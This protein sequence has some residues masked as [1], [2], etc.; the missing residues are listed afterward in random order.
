MNIESV[1][2]KFEAWHR[3]HFGT[4]VHRAA[5]HHGG[6][7]SGLE[8]WGDHTNY[9][10]EAWLAANF[11]ARELDVEAERLTDASILEVYRR[12]FPAGPYIFTND[13]S[14]FARAIE[15]EVAARFRAEG[16]NTKPEGA[17]QVTTNTAGTRMDGGFEVLSGAAPVSTEQ[18]G[19]AWISVED[20]LPE[21]GERVLVTRFAG[22]VI[23]PG[24]PGHP[25]VPWV[26]V[27]SIQPGFAIFACDLCS[28]GSVTHW[29][30]AQAAPFPNNSPVGA[31][32]E[33]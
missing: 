17:A 30:R 25:G 31:D 5:P 10:W 20:R 16:G 2:V 32:K 22:R 23:N 12:T 4:E 1:R 13:A 3:K 8:Y 21:P 14:K 7:K 24:H 29:K 28:T 27:S 11:A 19:D 33:P 18:A 6:N 9:A 26:E 15:A